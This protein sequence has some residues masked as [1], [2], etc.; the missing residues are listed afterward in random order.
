ML[1]E[2]K[3]F[4]FDM[5]RSATLITQFIAGKNFSDF[6]QDQMFRSAAYYQFTIIG[7][8][9]SQLRAINPDIA[10]RISEAHRIIGFR[11]QVIHGYGK[12]GDEITWR[13]IQTKLPI[14][15]NELAA[16]LAE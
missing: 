11:N 6:E 13:I 14:L 8:A 2:H 4:L 1:P 12:I 7:E 15:I 16:L 3:K 10:Q 9:L 5:Q